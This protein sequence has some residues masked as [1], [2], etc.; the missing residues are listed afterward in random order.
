[1]LIWIYHSDGM[2]LSQEDALLRSYLAAAIW[3]GCIELGH[4]EGEWDYRLLKCHI[5]QYSLAYRALKLYVI[6]RFVVARS[7]VSDA[8]HK[9][10][11][12]I[13]L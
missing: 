7:L 1:M 8:G 10:S 4:V 9:S 3:T 13:R 5:C 6:T 12:M 11:S 2:L